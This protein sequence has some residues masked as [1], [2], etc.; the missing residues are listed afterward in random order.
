MTFNPFCVTVFVVAS[1]SSMVA[2]YCPV[3]RETSVTSIRPFRSPGL[4]SKKIS[5]VSGL[6]APSQ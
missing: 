2:L 1:Y 3:P 6:K 4:Y 5:S